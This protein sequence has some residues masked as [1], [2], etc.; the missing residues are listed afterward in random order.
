MHR[1]RFLT[2]TLAA[3]GAMAAGCSSGSGEPRPVRPDRPDLDDLPDLPDLPDGLRADAVPETEAIHGWI[4]EIVELGVRRPGYEA[5]VRTEQML[6]DRLRELGLQ[7]VR[8]EPVP[9]TRWVPRSWSLRVTP[10]GG[11]TVELECFPLPY[12]APATGL[13]LD[14]VAFDG[15]APVA[16]AGKAAL[17]DAPPVRVAPTT[18]V[19]TGSAPD[20]PTGRVF[21]PEGT[22][23]DEQQILPHTVA[24][25]RVA[26]A[27]IEA[28]AAAFVGSLVDH[29]GDSCRHFVPYDGR[30]RPIPGVWV[31]GTDGAWLHEQ[32]ARGPVRARIDVDSTAEPFTS[33]NVVGVLPGADD[34]VV[35][36]GSHHDGPWASAVE[37]A[38]GVS[39]VLAQA[40]FWAAQPPSRRPHR[41]VFVLQAGHM[42]G[43]AGAHA[44]VEAHRPELADVVLEVHLEH[45]ALEVEV[46]DGGDDLVT[47]DRCTPRWFFTSPLPGLE[48]AVTDAIAAEQLARS[49][50][51]APD[52]LGDHPPTDGGAYHAERVPIVQ[53]ITAPSYLF[54]ETDRLDKI[55]RD[56]LVALTRA[57]VRIIDATRGTTAAAIRRRRPD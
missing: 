56:H 44:Y 57:V 26:D 43:G 17:V 27:V 48:R 42:C 3:A 6:V 20:D 30:S 45:A 38:S 52:A 7:D 23:E 12:T 25:N 41:M 35:M 13:E 11:D 9:V 31:R 10:D 32:L 18:F 55:D 50:L 36:V 2:G 14:L 28:G 49:M 16:V 33:H 47:T 37:D 46:A 15:S 5:D 53:F 39:L 4:E 51:L 8:L 22:F 19:G 54:D 34:D 24:R 40:A 1:R 21:D 29:P